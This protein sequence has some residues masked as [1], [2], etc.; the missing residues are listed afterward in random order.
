LVVIPEAGRNRDLT[1]LHIFRLGGIGADM[2]D[3]DL[4]LIEIALAS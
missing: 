3:V 1:I 4:L 2:L